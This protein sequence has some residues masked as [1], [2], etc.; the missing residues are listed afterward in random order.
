M[1]PARSVLVVVTRRIGDVLLTTPLIRSIKAA[2]PEA[3]IDVLVF[4]GTEGVLAANSDVRRVITIAERPRWHAHLR[5]LA[6]IARR[7]DVALSVVPSDRPT[8]Y[9]WLGGRW[10]AGIASTWAA[11]PTRTRRA[12]STGCAPGRTRR[13]CCR[14]SSAAESNSPN[15]R[16][17]RGA[18]RG[19]TGIRGGGNRIAA[20]RFR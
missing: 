6:S 5:L 15:R 7:Y 11:R 10:R 18:P 12:G 16:S 2:W 17:E 9:A 20:S 19:P 1:K 13:S 3:A 8:L 4:A 14:A